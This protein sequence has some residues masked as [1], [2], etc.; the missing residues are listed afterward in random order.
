MYK[1]YKYRIYPTDTQKV[2]LEKHFGCARFIYNLALETKIA[3]YEKGVKLSCF[4]LQRQIKDLKIDCEW[5]NEV[6]R[7]ALDRS[8]ANLDDAFNN[9]FKGK[10]F[11][12]FKKKSNS[13]SY[14][15]HKDISIRN[16]LHIPKFQEG[17][18]IVLHRAYSGLVKSVAISK[19]ATGKYFASVLCETEIS[20]LPKKETPIG[21]D[22]GL[23]SF[24]V[25]SDG[26]QYE[27]PKA[28]RKSLDR[29]AILQRRASVKKK[30][31]ANRRKANLKV[32][33]LHERIANQRKDFLHKT[34]NEIT[35]QYG[36]ICIEDLPVRNLVKNH[37]LALSI[38]DAGWGGFTNMLDYKSNWKGRKL[39]TIGRF[40]PSSKKCSNCGE[41][42][43]MPLSERTYNCECGM[44][45]DR[46][47]NAA[48]N[49]RNAGLLRA[50]EPMELP[51][52]VGAVK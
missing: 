8:I 7:H 40:Y 11:P 18:K 2:L 37:N 45:L 32:F 42:K 21:I 30:G 24:A 43:E 35:N 34:S 36:V 26:S 27:S 4:D 52:L 48:I 25:L 22:L 16:D 5:L 3:A 10:C 39:V 50:V 49:I 15:V 23:K 46:D 41:L 38:I 9:F 44:S 13:G 28:L 6:S 19:T 33:L 29:L 20:R 31:S 51:T 47:I 17:I 12:K 14:S 1:A